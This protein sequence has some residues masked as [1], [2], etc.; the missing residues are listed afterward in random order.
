MTTSDYNL[1]NDQASSKEF[2]TFIIF[3]ARYKFFYPSG[4]DI[5]DIQAQ[6]KNKDEGED[7]VK[8]SLLEAYSKYIEPMED[9][10]TFEETF[11]KMR[12]PRIR[13]FNDM[14]TKELNLQ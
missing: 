10:P 2:F 12:F 14:I 13:A 5:I 6:L 8:E 4:Q 11:K 1:D 9:A 3:G 7:E